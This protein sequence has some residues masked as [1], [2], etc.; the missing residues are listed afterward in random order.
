MVFGLPKRTMWGSDT[1]PEGQM[2]SKTASDG[3][4]AFR[5]EEL[6]REDERQGL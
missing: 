6:W 1:M 3:I 4:R 2:F 5:S